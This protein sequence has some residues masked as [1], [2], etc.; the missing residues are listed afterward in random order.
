[1]AGINAALTGLVAAQTKINGSAAN[2]VNSRSTF[3]EANGN[4]V[5]KPYEPVRVEQKSLADGGVQSVVLPVDPPAIERYDPASNIADENG[6][7]RYPNVSEDE[8]AITRIVAQTA[9]ESSL[10]VIQTEQETQDALLDV[11]N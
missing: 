2:T 9:Y 10:E 3:A 11:F 6:I 1:M 8:E 7:V 5:N 4:P